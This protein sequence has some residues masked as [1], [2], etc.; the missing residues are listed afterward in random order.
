[1]TSACSTHSF[2]LSV[3]KPIRRVRRRQIADAVAG[4]CLNATRRHWDANLR[5]LSR[6]CRSGL[7]ARRE[8]SVP[9][10]YKRRWPPARVHER[11][12]KTGRELGAPLPC[13]KGSPPFEPSPRLW[14][15]ANGQ[16]Q[17][18]SATRSCARRGSQ[19]REEMINSREKSATSG[20][21]RQLCRAMALVP[22]PGRWVMTNMEVRR[23]SRVDRALREPERSHPTHFRP[24]LDSRGNVS[25]IPHPQIRAKPLQLSRASHATVATA[26]PGGKA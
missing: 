25:R 16:S 2:T 26:A 9:E 14:P 15:H 21:M 3:T 13:Q 7:L 6:A 8:L 12:L 5:A 23:S 22:P 4:L 10:L 24:A 1:M 20:G 17:S 19:E 18:P 11:C